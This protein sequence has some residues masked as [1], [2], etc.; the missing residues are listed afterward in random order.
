MM[1]TA[2]AV[3]AVFLVAATPVRL[4]AQ[5]PALGG[6]PAAADLV[7]RRD[8]F[9]QLELMTLEDLLR[10]QAG[11]AIGRAGGLGSPELLNVAGSLDGR[12]QLVVDGVEIAFPELEWP[13]LHAVQL[14]MVDSVAIWRAMDPARIAIWTRHPTDPAPL[15]DIDLGRGSLV[16]RTRRVQ[17][18]TPPRALTVAV[19][20]DEV[21]RS[22]DEFRGAPTIDTAFD[23][24]AYDNRSLLVRIGLQHGDDRLQVEHLELEDHSHGSFASQQDLYATRSGRNALRWTR[25]LGMNEHDTPKALAFAT[26]GTLYAG[27][28]FSGS[29]ESGTT[30][31]SNG[32]WD[33]YVAA[34]DPTGKPLGAF[35]FGGAGQNGD[36]VRWLEFGPQGE[37]LVGGRFDTTMRV[38]DRTLHGIAGNDGYVVELSPSLITAVPSLPA[39][40]ASP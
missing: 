11:I 24:G 27:G 22:G 40:S 9:I 38:A 23:L 14:A 7:L 21:L 5:V 13:R 29:L 31:T 18:F 16:S 37:L 32:A 35:G 30:V 25:P 39:S 15:V 33:S 10:Q 2:F 3:G 8:D 36:L 19:V 1:R 34:F 12:V 28:H 4:R 20:Y 17:L 6:P 26:D